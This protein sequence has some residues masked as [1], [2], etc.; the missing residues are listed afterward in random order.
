MHDLAQAE[1]SNPAVLRVNTTLPP[2]ARA[3]VHFPATQPVHG[4][5][6]AAR[7]IE[8][9]AG[10]VWAAPRLAA[11]QAFPALG[12][13]LGKAAAT[14]DQTVAVEARGGTFSR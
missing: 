12:G 5:A 10:N 8:H 1:C 14:Q 6:A 9:A 2:T 7:L 3:T 13:G 11:G 4:A